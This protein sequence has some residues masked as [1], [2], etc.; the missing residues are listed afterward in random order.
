MKLV[1]RVGVGFG[2]STAPFGPSPGSEYGIG[3]YW[4]RPAIP[5]VL[6]GTPSMERDRKLVSST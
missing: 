6:V 4:V 1:S 5:N 3:P 2:P